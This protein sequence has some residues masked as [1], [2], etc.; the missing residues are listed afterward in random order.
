MVESQVEAPLPSIA[1]E[2]S[3]VTSALRIG[4][5]IAG[6]QSVAIES[7]SGNTSLLPLQWARGMCEDSG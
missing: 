1:S 7:L 3:A 5:K 2:F 6:P 4:R